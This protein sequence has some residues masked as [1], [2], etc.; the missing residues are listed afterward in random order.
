MTQ[1][2]GN[3]DPLP[4]VPTPFRSYWRRWHKKV[5]HVLVFLA[6]CSGSTMVWRHLGNSRSFVGQVETIQTI[7]SSRDSGFITNLWVEPLQEINIGDLVAEIITTDPRTVNNRLEVMRDRMRLMSLEMEPV[8]SRQRTALAYEE[9]SVD[10]DRVRSEVDVVRVRLEQAVSQLKRDE[11][12]FQQG[13]LSAESFELSRRNK[14]AFEAELLGK[15]N[16]VQRT[17]KA[18]E[19][20]KSVGDAFVPGGESDPIRQAIE[21]EEDKTRVFEAKLLPL[22]LQSPTNGIVTEVHRHAGEH[23]IAGEPIATI[24]STQIVRIIGYLPQNFPITPLV[25]MQ[26]EVSKRTLKRKKARAT[27]LGVSPHLE[28]ITNTLVTPLAARP[29]MIA[30]M[31]RKISISLPADLALLPGEPVDLMLVETPASA[32]QNA[33]AGSVPLSR[34]ITPP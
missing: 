18:L 2:R 31:G 4:P 6:L 25:G 15:S 7:V 21:L 11:T 32:V 9:L 24:T 17:E 14:E 1:L 28:S 8:L 3:I 26:V 23:V 20:L 29:V 12:L 30:P 19:R 16:L 33:K 34:A 10:C 5:A 27:V 13:A 22:R